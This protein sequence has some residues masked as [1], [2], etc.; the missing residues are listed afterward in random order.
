MNIR[1]FIFILFVLVFFIG[2]GQKKE[3]PSRIA[4][5]EEETKQVVGYEANLAIIQDILE[6]KETEI[7]WR[8]IY[9]ATISLRNLKDKRTETAFLKIMSRERPISLRKD[10]DIPGAM[11]PLNMLKAVAMESLRETG[12]KQYLEIFYKTYKETDER[13]LR[14]MAKAHIL[15]L[16]GTLP[17]LK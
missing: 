8:T 7:D 5:Q 10:S 15:A 3:E 17:K 6:V 11:N 1:Y 9:A 13:I 14:E 16:G 4:R 2:C 12:G